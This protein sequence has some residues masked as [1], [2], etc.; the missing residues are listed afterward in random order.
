MFFINI[1]LEKKKMLC[2]KNCACVCPGGNGLMTDA[3]NMC[4]PGEFN[5][6]DFD[7][8]QPQYCCK[9]HP[10]GTI[11]YGSHT[12]TVAEEILR[13]RILSC[14]VCK[15]IL[16]TTVA[17][18]NR[19]SVTSSHRLYPNPP[20]QCLLAR[21]C[22][23]HTDEK[24]EPQC[25]N[26]TIVGGKHCFQCIN[27]YKIANG[28]QPLPNVLG[29]YPLNL[30][31]CKVTSGIHYDAIQRYRQQVRDD[32]ERWVVFHCVVKRRDLK[33]GGF[34]GVLMEYIFFLLDFH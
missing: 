6:F 14:R 7:A 2:I 32:H 19:H 22:I 8:F 34:P 5:M 12:C 25:P 20:L 9:I 1:L 31:Q 21:R 3:H 28:R 17:R 24:E 10:K 13:M 30:R 33:R 15:R 29:G 26:A 23:S 27:L 4:V 16:T 18:T 11:D